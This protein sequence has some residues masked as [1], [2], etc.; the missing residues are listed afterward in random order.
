MS[1]SAGSSVFLLLGPENGEKEKFITKIK[2]DLAKRMGEAP[3]E[4][5]FYPFETDLSTVISIL[6]NNSL[7][8]SYKTAIL[9]NTEEIKRDEDIS[10]L[11]DYIKHPPGHTTLFMLSDSTRV[12][13][14]IEKVVPKTQKKIFWELFENRKQQ[15][16]SE[17]FRKAGVTIQPEAV[18]LFLDMVENNTRDMEKECE[19]LVLF[20]G[21][22]A[23]VSEEEIEKFIYHSK[24]ENVFTLFERIATQD[25]SAAVEILQKILQSGESNPAMLIGGLL[26]QF[27]KL[28][29]LR[30]LT[31]RR[32]N[33]EEAFLKADIKGRKNQRIYANGIKN[34]SSEDIQN[35]IVMIADYDNLLRSFRADM[36]ELLLS[37]FLYY[38]IKRKGDKS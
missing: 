26:W 6:R 3:E 31:D 20:F 10:L 21:E 29:H 19:K 7:F 16:V 22:R 33:P 18:E 35:I 5:H 34:Y 4:Y 28:K 37:I 13:K 30:E 1:N 2:T 36:H 17:Y 24:E 15:W 32:Y 38:C 9:N 8:A 12:H 14:K 27:K 25:F 11:S 23:T